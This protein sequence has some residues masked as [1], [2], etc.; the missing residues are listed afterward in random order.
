[1]PLATPAAGAAHQREESSRNEKHVQA[2]RSAKVSRDYR[3][4][5]QYL[6]RVPR[7]ERR[8]PVIDAPIPNPQYES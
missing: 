1:M 7:D 5:Q 6:D 4:G 3:P 8:L 2:R